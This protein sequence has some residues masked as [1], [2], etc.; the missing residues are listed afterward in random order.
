MYDSLVKLINTVGFPIGVSIYLLV[1]LDK[2][3]DSISKSL[4]ELKADIATVIGKEKK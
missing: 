4:N 3:L 1:R 2:K